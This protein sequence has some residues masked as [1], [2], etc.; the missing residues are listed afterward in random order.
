MMRN[1]IKNRSGSPLGHTL[2]SACVGLLLLSSTA[3]AEPRFASAQDSEPDKLGWMQGFPVP[4]DKQLRFADGSFFEFPALRWSVAHMRELMP[5]VNVSRG[6]AAPV[7]LPKQL[8]SEIGALTFIPLNSKQSMTWEESLWQNYTDGIVVLHKGQIV[9][10]R[11]FAELT[12]DRQH[13]A[14]SVTK[15]LTG[16]LGAVLV[17]EGKLDDTRLVSDYLPELIDS[18]FGD[19]TVRQVL[20]MTTALQFSED[21]ANPSAEIW[22][23]SAAG[24]PLP[25]PA[26]YTGP[27][28]YYQALKTIRKEGEHGEA[29][30]YKTPNADLLGWLIAKVSGKSVDELLAERVWSKIG[31]EQDANYSVD[32]LGTPF[33][34]GG[35]NAGLRDLARFGELVR[36]EGRWQGQQILPAQAMQ[37]IALGGDKAVF[38]K[39][40]HPELKGW[41]YRD[42]WWHT[43][44]THN[45]FAARG[46][47]GQTVYIDPKAQMVIVRFASHPIAGNSANDATSLPAYQALA[48]YLIKKDTSL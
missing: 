8:D 19:A 32:E 20:D 24:N 2:I 18:A 12:E 48:E 21:Y 15:S 10:E 9:Y 29:F 37:D 31:M 30:G 26:D 41:S 40:D 35:F 34:G 33:A 23:F 6:L 7:E 4:E 17:A 1:G 28:G 14:M 3:H 16:T 5:T 43:G 39:S 42:M 13:A 44:N 36:N 11:Y 47:H 27:I 25:K 46:V 22:A 38:A 45:G